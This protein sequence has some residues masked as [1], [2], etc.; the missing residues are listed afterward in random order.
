MIR[1][2]RPERPRLTLRDALTEWRTGLPMLS[3]LPILWI[4][5]LT[6]EAIQ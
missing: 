1:A 3:V 4:I 5:A 6:L 2:Y